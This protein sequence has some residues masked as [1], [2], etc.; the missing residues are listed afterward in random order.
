MAKR[1]AS[2]TK[3]RSQQSASAVSDALKKT[4]GLLSREGWNPDDPDR[5]IAG[6]MSRA[7]RDLWPKDEASRHQA[8]AFMLAEVTKRI[9]RRFGQVTI[10]A[11]ERALY[12]EPEDVVAII[13]SPTWPWPAMAALSPQETTIEAFMVLQRLNT[14]GIDIAGLIRLARAAFPAEWMPDDVDDLE[15]IAAGVEAHT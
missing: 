10:D 7:C 3:P 11:W 15:G 6:A 8:I 14:K 2:A 13:A 12:R 1:T 5:C 4:A 9:G